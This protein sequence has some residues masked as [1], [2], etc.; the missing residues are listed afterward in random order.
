[1][2]KKQELES[3]REWI[4]IYL[5]ANVES[6]YARYLKEREGK[7]TI[8]DKDGFITF[9]ITGEECF[10]E[11]IYVTP[12]CRRLNYGTILANKVTELAKKNNCTFLSGTVFPKAEGSTQS[13]K[14]ML[15][16]GFTLHSVRDN[17]IILTKKI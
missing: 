16:Y 7:Q 5:E 15:A 4:I 8:E 1:M 11:T 13:M 17:L 6:L 3:L 12:E 14:A 9:A 2:G 10:I